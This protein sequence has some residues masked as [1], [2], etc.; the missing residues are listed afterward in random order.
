M[1]GIRRGEVASPDLRFT[2][3]D[4]LGDPT[5]KPAITD[6]VCHISSGLPTTD[7]NPSSVGASVFARGLRKKAK[8]INPRVNKSWALS[9]LICINTQNYA[10]I[11]TLEHPHIFKGGSS[12]APLRCYTTPLESPSQNRP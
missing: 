11:I 1:F 7:G 4:G 12:H 6:F 8:S 5:P 2:R 9:V 10:K 3:P